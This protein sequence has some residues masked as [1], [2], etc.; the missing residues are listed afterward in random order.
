MV[1]RMTSKERIMQMA[2]ET[3]AGKEKKAEKKKK[4]T[5]RKKK[6]ETVKRYKA[7]WKVFDTG[8][9]EVACFPY[10]EKDEA[11]AKAKDLTKKKNNNHFVNEIKVLMKDE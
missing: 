5:T 1:K 4:A 3:V 11:N 6:V 10:S 2:G 8:Y 9:K 7:V